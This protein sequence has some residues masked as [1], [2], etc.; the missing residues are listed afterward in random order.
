MVAVVYSVMPL[1]ADEQKKLRYI[2]EN[3]RNRDRDLA[4]VFPQRFKRRKGVSIFF[5]IGKRRYVT[6]IF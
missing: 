3:S 2:V 6:N 5:D 1:T 4:N